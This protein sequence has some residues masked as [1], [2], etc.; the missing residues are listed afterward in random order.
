MAAVVAEHFGGPPFAECPGER[1]AEL[2]VI[3]FQVADA[4]GSCLKAA[5]QRGGRGLLPR[6]RNWR[7]GR[8]WVPLAE[9]GTRVACRKA[10]DP[11]QSNPE[12]DESLVLPC[13]PL[14]GTVRVDAW[15]GCIP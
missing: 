13:S 2:L 8:G 5:K 7:R 9:R 4:S 3:C 6:G 15:R 12:P 1:I 10:D 11:D 14:C